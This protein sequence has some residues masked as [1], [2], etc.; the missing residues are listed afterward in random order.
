MLCL[1]RELES[2]RDSK[3]ALKRELESSS[4]EHDR[5]MAAVQAK[6]SM[7]LTIADKWRER[8]GPFC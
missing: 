8:A 1:T 2:Q 4:F 3:E 7:A 5:D 6:L